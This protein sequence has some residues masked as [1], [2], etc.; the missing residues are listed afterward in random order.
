LA[1]VKLHLHFQGRSVTT[2][3]LLD[4]GAN[5]S[6]IRDDLAAALGLPGENRQVRFNTFHSA[7][8]MLSSREVN[9]DVS[10]PHSDKKFNIDAYTTPR[11]N[12]DRSTL[13][14]EKARR[15]WPYLNEVPPPAPPNCDIGLLIGMDV[16]SAHLQRRIISPPQGVDGPHAVQTELGWCVIGPVHRDFICS[17]TDAI[18][19]EKLQ[20]TSCFSIVKPEALPNLSD[21]ALHRM[22]RDFFKMESIGIQPAAEAMLTADE[23]RALLHAQSTVRHDK[24]GECYYV[25]L[26]KTYDGVTLP[27]N[28]GLASMML[29]RQLKKFA[30]QPEL[31]KNFAD[32]MQIYC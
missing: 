28:Y 27:N 6:L 7:D 32:Q 19:P 11:L 15:A 9:F 30:H 31:A 25:G 16:V 17:S 5:G 21:D 13:N 18:T 24:D 22:V 3:A 14:W 2:Y 20:S 26:P 23:K 12:L 29:Q 1:V 8:P 4:D 10:A